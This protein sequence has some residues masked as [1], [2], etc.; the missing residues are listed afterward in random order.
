LRDQPKKLTGLEILEQV[1]NIN[2]TLGKKKRGRAIGNPSQEKAQ[3]W[4]KKNIFF[5]LPYLEV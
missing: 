2:V 1:R 4:K 3:Q 5:E